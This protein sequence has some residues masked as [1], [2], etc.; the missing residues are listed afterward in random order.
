M[1]LKTSL[2]TA[3]HL[4]LITKQLGFSS[5]AETL[6]LAIS[7]ALRDYDD[8][9][10][11]GY[12]ED[13]FEIDTHTLFGS[14]YDL[15]NN[16][17]KFTMNIDDIEVDD[18]TKLIEFGFKHLLMEMKLSKYDSIRFTKRMIGELCT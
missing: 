10:D 1:R 4:D 2:N 15:F 11:V 8:I 12:D 5:K 17:I 3:E 18:Y 16:L 7:Y 14:E 9:E 6:K 13:G